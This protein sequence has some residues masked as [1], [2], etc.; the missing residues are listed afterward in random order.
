MLILVSILVGSWFVFH[1]VEDEIA[2]KKNLK[3]NLDNAT[4]NKQ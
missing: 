2:R 1:I 4:N 3:K